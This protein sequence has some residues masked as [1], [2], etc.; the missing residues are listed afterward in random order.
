MEH[1]Y[2]SSFERNILKVITVIG[3]ARAFL[4]LSLDKPE[5]NGYTDFYIDLAVLILFLW[6]FVMV[7]WNMH[8]SWIKWTFYLPLI[9]FMSIGLYT[10]QGLYSSHEL[11]AYGLVVIISLTMKDKSLIVFNILVLFGTI[12]SLNFVELKLPISSFEKISKTTLPFVFISVTVIVLTNYSKFVFARR[13]QELKAINESLIKRSSELNEGKLLLEEQ[14]S[15][16]AMLTKELETKVLNRTELLN[17]QKKSME[18]YLRLTLVELIQPYEKTL[19]A[20]EKLDLSAADEYT[21]MIV[22]SGERLSEE[23][24]KLRMQLMDYE[25]D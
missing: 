11:L 4:E 14:N 21:S 3:F 20:I 10:L 13:R 8:D 25:N 1:N 2:S 23:V 22:V 6:G 7:F 19:H 24:E 16:L 5:V 15:Q 12:V 17:D 9:L 18:K